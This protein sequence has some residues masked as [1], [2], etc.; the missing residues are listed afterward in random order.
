HSEFR[1]ALQRA[2]ELLGPDERNALR[3]H[4][5]HCMSIDRMAE[6]FGTQPLQQ[7]FVVAASKRKWDLL[8]HE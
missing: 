8:P 4:Y 2:I 5:L 3:C 6:V 7:L 1:L